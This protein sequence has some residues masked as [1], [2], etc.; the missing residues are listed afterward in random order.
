[1][2]ESEA[3]ESE[4]MERLLRNLHM[5]RAVVG[6]VL[7]KGCLVQGLGELT[8]PQLNQLKLIRS[9]PEPHSAWTVGVLAE[10]LSVTMAAASKAVSRLERDGWV[11]VT[12]GVEDGRQRCVKVSARG[13][14][15]V[16]RFEKLKRKRLASLVSASGSN[17][18]GAWNR[19]LERILRGLLSLRED[20][21]HACLLCGMY[22]APGCVAE[23]LGSNCLIRDEAAETSRAHGSTSR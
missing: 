3:S 9:S 19:S 8:F 4:A 6:D 1:M 11:D 17:E 22:E 2:S 12:G 16:A 20:V 18:V 5:M 10:R 21:S 13:R 15:A 23:S 14:R 7:E